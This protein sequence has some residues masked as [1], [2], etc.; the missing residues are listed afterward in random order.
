MDTLQQLAHAAVDFFYKEGK[1][2]PWRS[3]PPNPYHVWISEIMLQQ[4]RIEAVIPYFNRFIEKAPTI[5]ALAS[6]SNAELFKLWEG[7]GYYSRVVNLK[8]TAII[9]CQSYHGVLPADHKLLLSLPGIGPYTAGAIASIAFSLPEPAV[10]GNVLRLMARLFAYEENILTDKAK[11]LFT[12]MLKTVYSTVNPS[13]LT[14]GL[15][16]LGQHI[17]LPKPPRCSLCPLASFCL[18]KARKKTDVL[19]KREKNK[20]RKIVQKTVFLIYDTENRLALLKRPDTGLLAGLYGLPETE[21]LLTEQD[22]ASALPFLD[23]FTLLRKKEAVHIFTHVEWHMF[24]YMVRTPKIPSSFIAATEKEVSEIY[25]L[26][27]AFKKL[28]PEETP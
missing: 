25:A 20:V 24:G 6:L 11:K 3:D 10:D 1:N 16:E 9:L 15:M 18:A 28:L 8:K 4:T 14:Q 5:E 13:A 23:T 19:P 2:L 27:T 22:L 7:L 12:Q 17:C 26:P 21:K